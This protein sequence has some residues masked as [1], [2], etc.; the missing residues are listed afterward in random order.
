MAVASPAYVVDKSAFT[1]LR[2]GSVEAVL[3]PLVARDQ[4][5]TCGVFELEIL[6]SARDARDFAG[7]RHELLGLPRF[8]FAQTDFDRAIEVLGMLAIRGQHR[9]GGL[10]DLL[11][12][13]IAE[14]H[15][16]TV[17]HYDAHF[18]LIAAVTNQPTRWVVPRGSVA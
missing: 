8:D 18:D 12:A 9:A 7:V 17:L 13:A 5:A 6:Y 4:V 15:A 1:R 14:R 3:A 11:L 10:S 2:H 16:V